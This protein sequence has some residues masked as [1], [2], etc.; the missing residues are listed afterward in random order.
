MTDKS[1]D[2][3]SSLLPPAMDIHIFGGFSL[4]TFRNNS[5]IRS[6]DVVSDSLMY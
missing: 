2:K 1:A 4:H 5:D 6:S 3:L